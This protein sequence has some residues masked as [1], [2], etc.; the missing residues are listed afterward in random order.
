MG[1]VVGDVQAK[2]GD[3]FGVFIVVGAFGKKPSAKGNLRAVVALQHHR[4]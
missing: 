4:F 1:A 2:M 3:H